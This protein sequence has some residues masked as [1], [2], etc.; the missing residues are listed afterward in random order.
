MTTRKKTPVVLC[1]TLSPI[2]PYSA[3]TIFGT[4]GPSAQ[5]FPL[6][7]KLD[8]IFGKNNWEFVETFLIR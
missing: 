8:F 7:Q 6:E 5:V 4:I 2:Q 3:E 1:I